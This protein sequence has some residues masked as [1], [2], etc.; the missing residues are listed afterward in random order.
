MGL[1][2]HRAGA[3]QITGPWSLSGRPCREPWVPRV[4]SAGGVRVVGTCLSMAWVPK[5][6][7]KLAITASMESEPPR[8]SRSSVRRP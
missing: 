5:R 6:A 7:E 4:E 8:Q 2:E 3:V 1:D